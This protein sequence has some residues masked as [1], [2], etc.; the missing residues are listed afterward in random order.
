MRRTYAH[1]RQKSNFELAATS[2]FEDY[3]VHGTMASPERWLAAKGR[4][5]DAL[6]MVRFENLEADLRRYA[7]EFSFP[8]VAVP[9][10]N[11]TDHDYYMSYITPRAEEAIYRQFRWVFE[12]RLYER[13]TPVRYPVAAKSS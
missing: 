6:R 8:M 1:N 9:H 7:E 2:S 3:C 4:M 13:V 5:P 10:I 11:A 12:N